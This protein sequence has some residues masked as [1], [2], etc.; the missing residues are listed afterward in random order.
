MAHL[1]PAGLVVFLSVASLSMA[2]L[3]LLGEKLN[4]VIWGRT[5]ETTREQVLSKSEPRTGLLVSLV[6]LPLVLVSHRILH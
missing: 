4:R 6:S 2:P 5:G 3:Y 1:S